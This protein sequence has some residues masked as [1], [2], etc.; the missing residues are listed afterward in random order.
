LPAE[1]DGGRF[2]DREV[3]DVTPG[4][5]AT[6]IQH[7]KDWHTSGAVL[8]SS[9]SLVA[10]LLAG[11]DFPSARSIAELGP[12]TGCVTR[13]ILERMHPEARLV[14]LELNPVFVES[15]RSI[16]DSR[17]TVR[18]SCASRLPEVLDEEG[19]E[20]VDAVVSSLP[21]GMMD[22]DMVVRILRASRESLR[23][24]GTFVQY[25]YSLSRHWGMKALY[26]SVAV[27]FTPFN[28]PPAF[29]YTCSTRPPDSRPGGWGLVPAATGAAAVTLLAT[30]SRTV[31]NLL[32]RSSRKLSPREVALPPS[33][34]P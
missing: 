16:P 14:S 22:D 19:I 10:R 8:P 23:P 21:L 24:D 18:C 15:C 4:R 17:L 29:V 3:V 26:P 30:V 12:G 34:S 13:E 5:E 28:V 31:H 2:F 27:R 20:G 11:V 7:I 1:G 25:Q 33:A 32:E 9:R 6:L